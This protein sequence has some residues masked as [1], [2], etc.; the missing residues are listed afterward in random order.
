MSTL[1]GNILYFDLLVLKTFQAN[2]VLNFIYETNKWSIVTYNYWISFRNDVTM[3]IQTFTESQITVSP[4]GNN[5]LTTS[6]ANFKDSKN[7]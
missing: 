1:T 7:I 2:L 4:E 5:Q 6:L 3:A